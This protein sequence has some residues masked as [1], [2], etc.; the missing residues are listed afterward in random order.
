MNVLFVVAPFAAIERPALGVSVLK[1]RLAQ[2]GRRSDVAYLN[3]A[4]AQ[5]FGRAAYER[6]IWDLPFRALIGEWVFTGCLHGDEVAG[7]AYVSEIL[8]AE[9]GLGTGDIQ[10]ALDAR[11]LA[12][13]FLDDAMESVR[14]AD[15]DVVGFSS[16][17]AQNT[18]TLSIAER[19]KE[20]HPGA[21]IVCGGAN[22]RGESGSRFFERYACVDFVCQGD[23]ETSLPA[24]LDWLEARSTT[25]PRGISGI[26]YRDEAGRV[27]SSPG[28]PTR[29]LDALPAPDFTDFYADLHRYLGAGGRLPLLSAETSRGCWWARTGPC[30]FC[31]MDA[32]DREYRSKSSGRI[33]EELRQLSRG[34]GCSMIHLA[35]TV[36]SP[37]FL[38]DVLPA[39][40]DQPLPIPLFCDV[41]PD[42]TREQ[43]RL[44]GRAGI[45]IQPGIESLSDH[46]LRLMHKGTRGLEN[47][48]LL[49][50]CATYGV[51]VSW[52]IL[53]GFPGESDEDYDEMLRMTPALRFLP[54]PQVCQT[55]SVDRYSP[56]FEDPVGH[57]FGAL[58]PLAPYSHLYPMPEEDLLDVA[59]AFEYKCAPGVDL[60]P[61]AARLEAEMRAW[62]KESGLGELRCARGADGSRALVDAR[63]GG[64]RRTRRLDLLGQTIYAACEDICSR[65]DLDARIAAALD[66]ASG[67]AR[68]RVDGLLADLV[69]ERLMVTQ[70][71]RYLSLALPDPRDV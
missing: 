19:V 50:W 35:D 63:P 31:G 18:A 64:P 54:P 29:D 68:A 45:Q 46:V 15:Y 7:D 20:R 43:V 1:A 70:G 5:R 71:D 28:E 56:F 17:T 60:P 38:D 3:L 69:A 40:A 42:V 47:V 30:G 65:R 25:E 16:Y 33:L 26:L 13:A 2:A 41:R 52:N 59:Y 10:L 14:W 6:L 23:A 34:W 57:G 66:E 22:W 27:V 58:K 53:Y 61:V 37:G 67:A 24:L 21:T 51:R 9:W 36:V 62:R 55:L 32:Q 8:E 49:K 48:R 12:P 11:E 44:M 4:F 39:L